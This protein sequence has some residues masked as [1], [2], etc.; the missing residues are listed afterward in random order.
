MP[1]LVSSRFL[2]SPLKDAKSSQIVFALSWA[3]QLLDTA[4][5]QV[6]F[7]RGYDGES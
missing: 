5:E 3:G 2:F 6:C 7:V 4:R 1:F